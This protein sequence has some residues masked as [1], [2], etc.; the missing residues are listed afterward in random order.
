MEQ[1]YDF[2]ELEGYFQCIE[3]PENTVNKINAVIVQ[4]TQ[5]FLEVDNQGAE[6]FYLKDCVDFLLGLR[7]AIEEIKP[8]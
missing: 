7:C 2:K 1:K 3:T 5:W 8:I 4:L 6:E